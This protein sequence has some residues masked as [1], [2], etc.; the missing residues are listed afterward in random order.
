[1]AITRNGAT[2]YVAALGSSKIGIY[3]THRLEQNTFVADQANQIPTRSDNPLTAIDTTS[4]R[5][6]SKFSLYNP[7]PV[8]AKNG[9]RFLYDAR[10]SSA[11]TR[12]PM[13]PEFHPMKGP[14]TTQG[15]SGM[16]NA[17]PMNRRGDHTAGN[18]E[19]T[20]ES[21]RSFFSEFANF[22]EFQAMFIDLLEG[23]APA[24]P[25][26]TPLFGAQLKKARTAVL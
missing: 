19:P 16:Q 26:D 3:N 20:V 25:H 7:D 22:Q 14:T 2:R 11:H 10:H 21:D 9:R 4:R 17:S 6:V 12:Q 15:L 8:R 13:P 23:S 18:D 5:E 24:D 1:M